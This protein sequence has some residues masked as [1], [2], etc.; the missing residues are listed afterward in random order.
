MTPAANWTA[1]NFTAN[2][3]EFT[4]Y[5]SAARLPWT[6]AASTAQAIGNSA[7]VAASTMEFNGTGPHSVYGIG[8]LSAS[9]KSATTG[10]LVAGTRFANPR[11]NMSPG[12]RLALEYVLA[13]LDEADA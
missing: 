6:T 9:A 13:A 10:V 4:A 1:A 2:A 12:D 3:T 5:T 8:L 7:A 11:T